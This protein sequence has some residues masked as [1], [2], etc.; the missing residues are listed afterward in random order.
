MII[1]RQPKRREELLSPVWG[2]FIYSY[3]FE[4]EPQPA[5][6]L[7]AV[8]LNRHMRWPKRLSPAETEE[9]DRLCEDGHQ[10]ESHKREWVAPMD[11]WAARQT[12]LKRTFPHELGHY[13][14]YYRSVELPDPEKEDIDGWLRRSRLHDALPSSEKE[15]FAH[16][17]AAS[18]QELLPHGL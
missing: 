9:F 1:L 2:R 5:V 11:P 6:I 14:H 4:G 15:A 7:E 17:Y 13:V 8:N 18:I 3:D 10:F 16:R 12:Q